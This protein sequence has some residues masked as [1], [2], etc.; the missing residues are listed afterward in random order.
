M[1]SF[2]KKHK[3][4]FKVLSKRV[5][6]ISKEYICRAEISDSANIDLS[7]EANTKKSK[8]PENNKQ[9]TKS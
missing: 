9:M 5:L 3:N 6:C 2:L 1:Y 8:K 7:Y 4:Y